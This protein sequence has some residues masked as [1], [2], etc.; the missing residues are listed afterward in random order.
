MLRINYRTFTVKQGLTGAL[1]LLQDWIKMYEDGVG[2]YDKLEDNTEI[3]N[4]LKAS[5]FTKGK[6]VNVTVLAA[7]LLSYDYII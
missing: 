2:L 6:G 7:T 1:R 3:A 4:S 5:F